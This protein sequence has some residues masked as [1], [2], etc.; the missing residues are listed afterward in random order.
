LWI[1]LER[2]VTKA[3]GVDVFSAELLLSAG[4]AFATEE[5]DDDI[6]VEPTFEPTVAI[7]AC[8]HDSALQ[9]G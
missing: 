8:R 9:Q 3:K 6:E 5:Q 2:K 4:D 1:A 7:T